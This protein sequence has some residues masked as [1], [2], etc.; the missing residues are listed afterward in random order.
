[1][2]YSIL[3][4]IVT[5]STTATWANEL[6]A[7][8]K[9]E[10]SVPIADA[11]QVDAPAVDTP[12]PDSEVATPVAEVSPA[13]PDCPP[14]PPPPP[15]TDADRLNKVRGQIALQKI[16]S[17][18]AVVKDTSRNSGFFSSLFTTT[19]YPVDQD[20]LLNMDHFII[21]HPDLPETAEV[22]YLKAQV[23]RRMEAYPATAVDLLMLLA[24][25]PDSVWHNEANKQ[26]KELAA[27]QL[28]KQAGTIKDL[29]QKARAVQGERD[30]RL[31]A[32]LADVGKTVNEPVF[33]PA[34]IAEST[35]FLM[36]NRNFL[37]EDVIEHALAKQ[38]ALT[39]DQIAIAHFN[40]LLLLYP[41]SPLRPDSLLSLANVQRKGL[42]QFDRAGK[43]YDQLI[44][45]YPASP[46]AKS[47]HLAL[48]KMYEEEVFNYPNALKA[49][50]AIVA[51]YN[52][53][54]IVLLSLRAMAQI[55]QSRV[56][57]PAKAVERHIR[58]SET[59]KGKD[60]LDALNTAEGIAV[61]T[62]RDWKTA[63]EINDRIIA[64]VPGSNDAIKALFANADI[65]DANLK[66]KEQAKKRYAE[67]ITKHPEHALAKEA[68]KRITAMESKKAD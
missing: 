9:T 55:Y 40:K 8:E 46:E 11:A 51:K 61:F 3:L 44:E 25:Y 15:E 26:L 22:F 58:I 17:F 52:D 5:L 66:D 59:F 50:D 10:V 42:K 23:H 38:A 37:D 35:L 13:K 39:D 33:A 47:G 6:P 31:A 20:L 34:L 29:T 48:A 19:V 49:Y 1:M 14:P 41:D 43:T 2:R 67:V 65:T 53:D 16:E 32:Y 28:K 4:V 60:A 68:Q 21:R 18:R 24:A 54:P 30:Q 27:D 62:L 45:Q 57:Q 64:L 12:Q 36:S 63:M 56:S 7:P